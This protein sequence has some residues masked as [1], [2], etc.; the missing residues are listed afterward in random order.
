YSRSPRPSGSAPGQDVSMD[1]WLHINQSYINE[2]NNLLICSGRHQ[3]A[4][5]GVNV[6]S[7]ELRF[8]MAN[9]EDWSDEFKQYLL[10]P[11][12]DDGVPLYDL[13]SPGGIDA[14]D[15]NF[16]TWGQHNIVEIPNDEP[17]IPEFMVFDNGNYRSREDAKSLLP[18]DNFSRVVQF[19]INLNTMTVTRPYEYGKTEVGN[20]GYSSFVSAKHLLTNGHLVIHFGAT[21]VDEFEHTITAQPGS[22][23]L[24]DP[25]E[26]QQALGR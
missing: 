18:L 13:T 6:D 2:P 3:S 4:I 10:T 5:F 14:A 25:D 9:H 8:I 15:K 7:G 23:D 16:W 12:D 19:K 22:S 26:G 11:V 17:G 24:V 21:T 1:D 20:R